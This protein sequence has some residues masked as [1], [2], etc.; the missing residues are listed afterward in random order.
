M[1]SPRPRGGPKLT[2]KWLRMN[3][4]LC[5]ENRELCLYAVRRFATALRHLGPLQHDREIVT[6]SISEHGK[7]IQYAS[8]ELQQDNEMILLAIKTHPEHIRKCHPSEDLLVECIRAN[9]TVFYHLPNESRRIPSIITALLQTPRDRWRSLHWRSLH[10]EDQLNPI[11]IRIALQQ[12]P[13]RIQLPQEWFRNHNNIMAVVDIDPR[14]LTEI[15]PEE[16]THDYMLELI[17]INAKC[18]RYM[19]ELFT[20]NFIKSAVQI[21]PDVIVHLRAIGFISKSLEMFAIRCKPSMLPLC[22]Y[23]HEFTIPILSSYAYDSPAFQYF[24]LATLV[25]N[26]IRKLSKHG[27][28]HQVMLLRRI[29]SYLYIHIK[30]KERE[31]YRKTLEVLKR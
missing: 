11:Y 1:P 2:I 14:I 22:H 3:V 5:L 25:E 26:P 6:L 7:S 31:T 4:P 9:P 21:N 24:M 16:K 28:H 8:H 29:S 10:Y 27:P 15:P 30:S 18:I 12:E 13:M 20:Y 19:R 17:K 23:R